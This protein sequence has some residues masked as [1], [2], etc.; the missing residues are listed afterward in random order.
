MM[1]RASVLFVIRDHCTPYDGRNW[2]SHSRP[3]SPGLTLLEK[4]KKCYKDGKEASFRIQ[5]IQAN[6]KSVNSMLA[7]LKS[8]LPPL[9]SFILDRYDT[10]TTTGSHEL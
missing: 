6:L 5:H 7:E 10:T 1:S 2:I 4:A 9:K 8:I 3:V